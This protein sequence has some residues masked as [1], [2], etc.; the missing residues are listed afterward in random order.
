MNNVINKDIQK[1]VKPWELEKFD[2]IYNRDERFFALIIK[3]MLSWFNRNIILY[4]KPIN[5]FIFNTG[6]SYLYM[7]SN[8]YEFDLSQ[9][10]G[11]NMMYMSLPRCI[12]EMSNITIML[13]ELS[14]G[15]VNG[16]YNRISN[17]K[18]TEFSSLMKRI[19]LLMEF[20]LK[21]TLSNFNELIILIQEIIDKIIFNKYF[22]ITYL[23]KVIQCKI[24]L[25][26]D[27]S[28]DINNVDMESP[29][30]NTRTLQIPIKLFSSYPSIDET[31]E[32]LATNIISHST[33]NIYTVADNTIID[34]V[35]L[36]T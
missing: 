12:V 13:E 19:P 3:G 14:S 30:T 9:T 23:G 20:N 24:E 15:Y 28:I 5:H 33:S 4:N 21:Y 7:E 8:G 11:E 27:Y 18:L 32:I 16:V 1:W 34:Q 26:G 31:S 2:N 36:D 29:E 10:T 6:S 22:N 25:G 35:S 17:N